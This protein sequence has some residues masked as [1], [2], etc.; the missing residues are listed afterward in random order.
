VTHARAKLKD[1]AFIE[2]NRDCVLPLA[3]GGQRQ[4]FLSTGDNY[5]FPVV[6]GNSFG[7]LG[8]QEL[9]ALPLRRNGVL[10]APALRTE[11]S[12]RGNGRPAFI[13]L[14]ALGPCGRGCSRR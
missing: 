11:W 7:C 13:Q 8:R 12:R 6:T 5:F 10:S 14:C 1:S 9:Q 4:L 3:Y 2:L